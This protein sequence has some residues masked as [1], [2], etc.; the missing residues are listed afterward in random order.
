MFK[1]I[2]DCSPYYVLFTYDGLGEYIK[3][4][5]D[6]A[7]RSNFVVSNNKGV[8]AIQ[9]VFPKYYTEEFYVKDPA[10]LKSIIDDNPCSSLLSLDKS[11]AFLTTFP[12]VKSPIH[13]DI[14]AEINAPV[15][16][17]IN[18]PIF[19]DDDK[20]ITR[21]YNGL[22]LVNHEK[23]S[24]IIDETMNQPECVESLNFSMDYAI[25]FN[26]TI[27]HEWDNTLSA[28]KRTIIGMRAD[29]DHKDM[30]FAQAKTILFGI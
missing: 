23:I 28:N 25:L 27:Y 29:N 11:A 24:Y 19:V 2:K 7:S 9:Q 14:N 6:T 10:D 16:F 1:I 18:Y 21:W 17:R 30:T 12:G 26:T 5:Q 15:N 20:C 8:T 22:D 4:L 13:L 3:M